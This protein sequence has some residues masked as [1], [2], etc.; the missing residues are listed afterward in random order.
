VRQR[1]LDA[2]GRL[3]AFGGQSEAGWWMRWPGLGTYTFSTAGP[4]VVEPQRGTDPARLTDSYLRGVVPV[5]LLAREH[6]ALHASAVLG[7]HGLTAFCARSG[8]GKSSLALAV[9]ARGGRLWA[10]DTVVLRVSDQDVLACAL[11]SLPR[12]DE[13]VRAAF[14]P[15]TR[16]DA[17]SA[18]LTAPLRRVYLIV[19]DETVDPAVPRIGEVP[20]AGAFEKLLAHAHPFDLSGPERRRRMIERMLRVARSTPVFEVRFAPAL[21]Q[22]P[23]L[24]AAVARHAGLP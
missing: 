14:G 13:P 20:A 3:V 7:T 18:G 10:D 4:V 12:V 24:A 15:S 6:E 8:T 21:P 19:R 16:P 11:P 17:P 23:G 9:A 22:L 1:W 2:F 5:V